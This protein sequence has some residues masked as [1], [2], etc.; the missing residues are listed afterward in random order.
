MTVTEINNEFLLSYDKLMGPS[1][2]GL[3]DYEIS[4]LLTKGAERKIK[5][6]Y[7][8]LGNKYQ[9][10]YEQSEKRKKELAPLVKNANLTP[11]TYDSS[12]NLPNGR[13]VE[14]PTDFMWAATEE[15]TVSSSDTCLNGTRLE[16]KPISHDEYNKNKR[17]PFKKPSN[18]LVW[19]MDYQKDSTSQQHEL[20]EADGYDITTY[21]LRYIKRPLPI[22]VSD[23]TA[24][25]GTLSIEGYNVPQVIEYNDV[26]IRE[27][28][29]EAVLIGLEVFQEQR[30]ATAA[31]LNQQKTE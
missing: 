12:L 19:R 10:G 11:K 1:A 24:I 25:P 8:P 23:L 5:Q 20:I 17:N 29:D 3:D 30:L 21:H 14:L 18:S 27:I 9:E 2:P 22:I 26:F 15:V 6:V 13:F 16:I 31:Q 7:N 28:I 4:V